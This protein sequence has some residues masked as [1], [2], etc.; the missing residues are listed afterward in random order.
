MKAIVRSRYG[1][2]DVLEL[3]ELD[4]PVVSDQTVLVR[5]RASSLNSGDLESL[6]GKP[7]IA[8]GSGLRKPRN[9]GLGV[10]VAGEVEA[11]GKAVTELHPGDE[12]FGDLT[13]HGLGAFAEYVGAPARAFALKPE[14]MTFEEA[15]TVPQSAVLALQ[16]LRGKHRIQP[17]QRVLINGAGGNVGPFAVQIAKSFG[18][19]VT[20]VDRT[21][22]L[23][24][25]RSIGADHVIDFTREEFTRNGQRYDRILDLVARGSMFE[26]KRA[27]RPRGV[28]VL[29]GASTALLLQ[30][31]VLGPLISM[32]R[33]TTMGVMWWWRPFK[34]EDVEVLKKLIA[35]GSLHPV[36][37]KRYPLSEV[38]A[39]LEYL[40]EGNSRGKIVITT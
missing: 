28:Y 9:R 38:P 31:A 17:G 24:M 5:V 1:S 15:A 23:D 30:G 20:A 12:V 13:Q 40:A 33:S 8:R 37:D 18:A 19:D 34:L 35:A 29:Q 36:I 27:L 11:V 6:R 3:Q 10:D 21:S 4:K 2:P 32:T 25:L 7:L 16:G 26:C 39:A 14:S 22:K